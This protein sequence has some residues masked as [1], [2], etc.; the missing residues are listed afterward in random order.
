MLSIHITGR[1]ASQPETTA[2]GLRDEATEEV[3][4][5]S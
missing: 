2:E 1:S 5:P 3:L 4:L